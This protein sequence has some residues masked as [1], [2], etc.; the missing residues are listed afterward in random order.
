MMQKHR[1]HGC[2]L[3]NIYARREYGWSV[4]RI[5]NHFGVGQPLLERISSDTLTGQFLL[6][7][8]LGIVWNPCVGPTLSATMTLSSQGGDLGHA[9]VVMALFGAVAGLPLIVLG[10]LSHQAMM[11]FKSKLVATGKTG[12]VLLGALLLLGILIVTGLDKAF[13]AWVLTHAPE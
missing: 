4:N 9:A 11:R 6:G 10:T 7:L 12:K 3:T 1:W 5:S 2:F 13:E 8:V